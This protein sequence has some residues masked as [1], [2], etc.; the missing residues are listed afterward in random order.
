MPITK[1]AS[2]KLRSDKR[3]Q[4]LNKIVRSKAVS[5]I[6]EFRKNV[7]EKS[8]PEV[9]SALDRAAKNRVFHPKKAD[10]LKARLAKL[11]SGVTKKK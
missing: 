5:L 11:L 2:K 7:S 6:K 9:F 4:E 1:S 10:R 8:L 3:K